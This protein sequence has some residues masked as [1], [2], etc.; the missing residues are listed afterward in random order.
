MTFLEQG[1]NKVSSSWRDG[2]AALP[3]S[4]DPMYLKR[5]AAVSQFATTS[6]KPSISSI[7]SVIRELD[8]VAQHAMLERHAVDLE[9]EARYL[10]RAAD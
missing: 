10:E 6:S 7:L 1:S 8:R 3:A 9:L 2:S 4:S 5:G